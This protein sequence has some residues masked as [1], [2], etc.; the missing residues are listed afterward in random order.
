MVRHRGESNKMGQAGP[1]L[2]AAAGGLQVQTRSQ[3]AGGAYEE[4]GSEQD[5]CEV[6]YSPREEEAIWSA[7]RGHRETIAETRL[8][9]LESSVMVLTRTLDAGGPHDLGKF[10]G[11][12]I[13]AA[14]ELDCFSAHIRLKEPDKS[15]DKAESYH[16]P[17]IAIK[18]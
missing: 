3:T 8:D 2:Q 14:E 4:H 9:V 7:N 15:E 17:D 13:G 18:M 5:E 12:M 6:G 10:R 11:S 1:L 16:C